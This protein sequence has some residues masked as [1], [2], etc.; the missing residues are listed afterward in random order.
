MKF[1]C[2]NKILHFILEL[3]AQKV[4]EKYPTVESQAVLLFRIEAQCEILSFQ[5]PQFLELNTFYCA[6]L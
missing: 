4:V 6:V 5:I 3:S 2:Q 1:H